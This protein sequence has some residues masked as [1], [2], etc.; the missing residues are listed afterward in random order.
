[1]ELLWGVPGAGTDEVAEAVAAARSAD[2]VVLVL[3]LASWLEGE[4]MGIAIEGFHRGDRTSLELPKVQ[5]E[6]MK[7]VVDA[8][9][10]KP[11]VLVLM[12]GSALAVTWA[13]EHVPA[14]LQAWY[15]GQAAGTAVADIL[16]GDESPGGRL[17]ITFYRSVEQLPPFEDYAME[18]RTYRYFTGEPLYPFGHGLSY[19]RFSYDRL[20]VPKKAKVGEPVEVSARVRNEGSVAADEVV[21]VYVS[22][23]EAE[24]P[25]PLR[26]LKAFRRVALQPGEGKVVRFT[27]SPRELSL[28]TVEGERVVEPGRLVVAVGGTQPGFAE[29]STTRVVEAPLILSGEPTRLDP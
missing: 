11:V 26:A 15:P 1:V 14:I 7:K 6:L 20:K 29:R 28:A 3:G 25:A 21:Q 9:E 24:A 27:L 12:S 22:F 4:E 13:D 18:G 23:P 19:A 8:S 17:P 16:F 10:G 2:A 5:R